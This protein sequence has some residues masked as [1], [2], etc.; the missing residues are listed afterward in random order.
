MGA[1]TFGGRMNIPFDGSLR[2]YPQ[3]EDKDQELE[4]QQDI[5]DTNPLN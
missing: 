3:L 4:K 2:A 5:I 1:I